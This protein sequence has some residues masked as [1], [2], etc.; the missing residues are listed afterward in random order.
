MKRNKTFKSSLKED[1]KN[2]PSIWKKIKSVRYETYSGGCSLRV[3]AVDL[4]K[5]ERE[6][7][8]KILEEYQDGHF[9]SM[10][11]IYEYKKE[12]TK[13]ER[14]VK[15]AFLNNDFSA[16]MRACG[17]ASLAETYNVID[18]DTSFKTFGCDYNTALWRYLNRL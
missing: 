3:S 17:T 11:D 13:K 16:E 15:Y 1:F 9:N 6:I 5:D 14:S 4:L 12:G 2:H 7:V 10:E 18:N 8:E